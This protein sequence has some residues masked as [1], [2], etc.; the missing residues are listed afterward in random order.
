MLRVGDRVRREKELGRI[1]MTP[2]MEYGRYEIE[3][4]NGVTLFLNADEFEDVPLPQFC[5]DIFEEL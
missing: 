2:A 3:F 1:R 5:R 4:D